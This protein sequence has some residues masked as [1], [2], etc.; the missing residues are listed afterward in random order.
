MI[1]SKPEVLD[2]VCAI[3]KMRSRILP[4]KTVHEDVSV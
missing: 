3:N 2:L 1:S 4:G